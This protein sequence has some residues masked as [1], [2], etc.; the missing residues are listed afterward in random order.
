MDDQLDRRL[1]AILDAAESAAANAGEVDILSIR[2]ELEDAEE[3]LSTFIRETYDALADRIESNQD[4]IQRL[5][6]RLDEIAGM[7]EAIQSEMPAG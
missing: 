5:Q 2:N 4:A 1:Q 3:R 6:E 7:V